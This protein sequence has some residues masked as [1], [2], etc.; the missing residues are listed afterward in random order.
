[1]CG[2]LDEQ[3]AEPGARLSLPQRRAHRL[4]ELDERY[5]GG[6]HGVL[7]QR[8]VGELQLAHGARRLVVAASDLERGR[9][10][11]RQST[12]NA[13]PHDDVAEL[14]LLLVMVRQTVRRR[15]AA[16]RHDVRDL[17]LVDGRSWVTCSW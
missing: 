15:P 12:S 13:R 9:R 14:T 1:M 4:H 7:D 16:D 6:G 5:R 3:R 17:L 2:P 8:P 10:G 11:V